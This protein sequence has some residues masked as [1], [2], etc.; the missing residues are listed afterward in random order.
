[1]SMPMKNLMNIWGVLLNQVFPSHGLWAIYGPECVLWACTHFLYFVTQ[2]DAELLL[3]IRKHILLLLV[4][5][6][7]TC[8]FGQLSSL[9]CPI[10]SNILGCV[11]LMNILK[12]ACKLQQKLN[13][14]LKDYLSI[15]TVKCRTK[16]ILLKKNI[17]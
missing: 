14:I 13:L 11:L 9:M 15:S 6:G 12:N 17:E 4:V 5:F 1:M 8:C 7:S 10:K 16:L 2:Y 3:D